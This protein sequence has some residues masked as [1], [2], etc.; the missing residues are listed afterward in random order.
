MEVSSR[1]ES[2]VYEQACTCR[3]RWRSV[4]H[5]DNPLTFYF[6]R[7]GDVAVDTREIW[8]K[9]VRGEACQCCGRS[10]G[11][12]NGWESSARGFTRGGEAVR[13]KGRPTRVRAH[14]SG[15]VLRP[16]LS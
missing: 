11:G 1:V 15:E 3:H 7:N 10:G 6:R 8:Y 13:T 4:E 12:R 5:I 14:V 2:R 16:L 9:G